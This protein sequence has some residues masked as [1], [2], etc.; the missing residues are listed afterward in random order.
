MGWELGWELG[1]EWGGSGVGTW[2]RGPDGARR[3]GGG[4][5]GRGGGSRDAVRVVV[6]W[7][8]VCGVRCAVVCGVVCGMVCGM[9]GWVKRDGARRLGEERPR[10]SVSASR[11]PR[12]WSEK[13]DEG[14]A[15][16]SKLN[17]ACPRD[18]PPK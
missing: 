4:A 7:R 11:L 8:V 6:R 14:A 5:R 13:I 15:P 10:A 9:R 1:W 12:F 17:V 3:G 2:D 16:C 18:R